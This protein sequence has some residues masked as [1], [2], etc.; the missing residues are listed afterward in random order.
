MFGFFRALQDD[1]LSFSFTIDFS[2]DIA[3]SNSQLSFNGMLKLRCVKT[4]NK[5][6]VSND[7]N[8]LLMD[9]IAKG[10]KRYDG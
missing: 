9:R 7:V 5:N 4:N 10:I 3:F 2:T 6:N 1:E 8:H